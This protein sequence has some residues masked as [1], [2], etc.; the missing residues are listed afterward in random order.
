MTDLF[1]LTFITSLFLGAVAAGI[2]LLLAG[3]GEQISEKAGVLNIGI[4]GMM[5]VGEYSGF[6]AAFYLD[7]FWLGFLFGGLG[8]MAVALL[9]VIFC[10]WQN[11]NQ[12]VI[13]IALTLGAEGLTSLLHHFEF[14]RT[15]PRLSLAE[16][17]TIPGLSKLPIVGPVLFDQHAV[18]YLAIGLMFFLMWAYKRT[19]VG[20][21][22]QAVGAMSSGL[23]RPLIG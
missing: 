3:I 2:P 11:M 7:S 1:T 12:I 14:S 8:G 10:V 21:N 20:L 17:L 23:F 19:Y 22:L 6:S 18:V 4:E 9:M 15:Y 5:L 13:G 16:N